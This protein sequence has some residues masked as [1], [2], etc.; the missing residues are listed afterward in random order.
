MKAVHIQLP[1]ERG[2]VVVLEELGDE[3]PCKFVFVQDNKRTA[4]VGPPNE[5]CIFVVVQ[6][7]F[8]LRL[9]G[10]GAGET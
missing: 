10:A 5:V 1:D 6:E 8:Q 4:V 2:V 7:A 3:S 9:G